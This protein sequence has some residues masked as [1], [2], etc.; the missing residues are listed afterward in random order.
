MARV[1][2]P[3]Q[4]AVLRHLRTRGGAS[5]AA[6]TRRLELR[7]L[8]RTVV[9]LAVRGLVELTERVDVDGSETW[10]V[11]ISPAGRKAAAK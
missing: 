8:S 6:I 2:S 4:Q 11:R 3:A 9:A 10:W 5:L 1:P 7:N